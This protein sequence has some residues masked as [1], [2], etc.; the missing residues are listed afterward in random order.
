MIDQLIYFLYT[1]GASKMQEVMY[2]WIISILGKNQIQ[3]SKSQAIL[4]VTTY[5]SIGVMSLIILAVVPLIFKIQTQQYAV[6]EF[7]DFIP[8]AAVERQISECESFVKS[9]DTLH[10][11]PV[12]LDEEQLGHDKK[13]AKASF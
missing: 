4:D 7:L 10:H 6:L 2:L 13:K 12:E 11:H 1:N 3:I 5:T 8:K 9:L